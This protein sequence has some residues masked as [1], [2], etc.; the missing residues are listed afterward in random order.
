VLIDTARHLLA[1]RASAA[2][3]TYPAQPAAQARE[4]SPSYR[5]LT[6]S[7]GVKVYFCAAHSPWQ[8]GSYENTNG[9]LRQYLP[10]DTNLSAHIQANL[11]AVA[12]S[13]SPQIIC[14]Q[15]FWKYK[16]IVRATFWP[17]PVLPVA[18][19]PLSINRSLITPGRVR[20]NHVAVNS[21]F[22]AG[23]RYQS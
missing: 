18:V 4:D 12:E 19:E 22:I 23:Y 8:G 11:D 14:T 17:Y 5:G 16:N 6:E 7:T 21:S 15:T 1:F 20:K 3:S 10:K 2:D 13:R 9:L